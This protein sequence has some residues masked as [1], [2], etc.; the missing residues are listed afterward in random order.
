MAVVIGAAQAGCSLAPV[1]RPTAGPTAVPSP[2]QLVEWSETPLPPAAK[3][4]RQPCA[5]SNPPLG[6]SR[7]RYG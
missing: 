5:C 3:A 6:V 1:L 2:D 4:E 7:F